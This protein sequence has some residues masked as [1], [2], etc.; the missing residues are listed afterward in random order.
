MGPR[1]S[2]VS[3]NVYSPTLYERTPVPATCFSRR[4]EQ[5]RL[6]LRA[7]R[8]DLS[9]QPA[10]ECRGTLIDDLE[11][12]ARSVS[13]L[14]ICRVR[15]IMKFITICG[16]AVLAASTVCC[17]AR[18]Q[19]EI[20]KPLPG[21][22]YQ[23][24]LRVDPESLPEAV[25]ARERQVPGTTQAQT[26]LR[27]ESEVPFLILTV[28]RTGTVVRRQKIVGGRAYIDASPRQAV[29]ENPS[30]EPEWRLLE[31]VEEIL[32]TL[33]YTPDTIVAGR[34]RKAGEP[35]E[36]PEPE[37]FSIPATFGGEESPITGE[38]VYSATPEQ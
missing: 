3:S 1:F 8:R 24:R 12:S 9:A 15:R 28:N 38:I 21:S 34:F 14:R 36:V 35:A 18:S 7:L 32:L 29:G 2:E 30:L 13:V 17:A 4:A 10:G 37:P 5:E 20:R 11:Q 31:G 6:P 33:N 26:W 19:S 16:C 25:R 27:N 22:L 23:F